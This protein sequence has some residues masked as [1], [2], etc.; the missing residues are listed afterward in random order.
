MLAARVGHGAV[1]D[2]KAI[3]ETKFKPGDRVQCGKIGTAEYDTGT[4]AEVWDNGILI[5]DWNLAQQRYTEDPDDL[6]P[7]EKEKS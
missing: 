6:L 2:L 7:L 3:M 4:V 5:V 1:L